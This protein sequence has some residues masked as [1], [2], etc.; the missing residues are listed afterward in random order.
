MFLFFAGKW[1]KYQDEG[2][3]KACSTQGI[4]VTWSG[5]N[6][7]GTSGYKEEESGAHEPGHW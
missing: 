2:D 1:L 6:A 5:H 3:I 7:P 4:P